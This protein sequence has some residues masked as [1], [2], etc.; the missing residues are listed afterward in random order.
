MN[1]TPCASLRKDFICSGGASEQHGCLIN[2]R[3]QFIGDSAIV[4]RIKQRLASWY[5]FDPLFINGFRLMFVTSRQVL[6]RCD[7][8]IIFEISS[9][10]ALLQK[11]M[12]SPSVGVSKY[13]IHLQL[14]FRPQQQF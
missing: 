3:L 2:I 4:S 11:S 1:S 14:M 5:V 8:Y 10:T 7:I 13:P 12:F 6:S 9:V